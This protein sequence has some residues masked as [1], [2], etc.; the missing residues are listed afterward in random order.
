ML[1]AFLAATPVQAQ[2]KC[3]DRTEALEHLAT[4]YNEAPI[5]FGLT[6]TGS[7]LEVVTT[8]DGSTWTIII[9][10]PNGAT[11]LIAAGQDWTPIIL[12]QG[13]AA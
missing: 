11:C 13:T 10:L 9:T 6:T 7:L 4:K 8:P 3:G 1:A 5:A 2:L 12:P